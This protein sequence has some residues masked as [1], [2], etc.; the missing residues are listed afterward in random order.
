MNASDL[1]TERDLVQTPDLTEAVIYTVSDGEDIHITAEGVYV[2]NGKAADVTVYVE[3]DDQAKVQIVLDGVTIEN[4]DFPCIYVKQAD[5]VYV[6]TAAE[7]TLSVTGSFIADGDTNTDA[8]I[9]SKDD[10][11]LNGA[12]VLNISSTDNG[13][14][15]KDDL[16]ITG[17][18][19]NITASSKAF[20]AN[21]SIRIY[22]GVFSLKAGTDCF[23]AENDED[24]TLGY[25]YICGGEFNLESGDDAVHGESVVQIDGG[26]FNISAGEGIE[27]TY[28]QI[29]DGTINIT[30]WDDGI[31]AA[32]KSDSYR[33]TLEINGGSIKVSVTNGDTDCI[34]VN[35]DLYIKGGT[36]NVTGSSVFDCDGA[37]EF[38]GGTVIVNG[39]E[40][41]TIPYSM[42]GGG[43]G[44]M[45]GFMGGG[46]MGRPR[47]G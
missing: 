13:V 27:G 24:D 12:S 4:A 10:L 19:Y 16:K 1:F 35:G 28:I 39:S 15:S 45:G 25:I 40:V 47:M 20:E 14:V 41:D 5:K 9:F 11:V 21:D 34:D 30:S 37:V 7:S 46:G 38:T 6:T 33:A 36:V 42:G 26:T 29:N 43:M 32:Q 44:N 8:V 18:T 3:A 31:N 22:D 2:L 23:H 17:G